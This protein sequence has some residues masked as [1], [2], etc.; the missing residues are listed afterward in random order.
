MK[1]S[2]QSHKLYTSFGLRIKDNLR[3]V[4]MGAVQ[5][6]EDFPLHC[7]QCIVLV[8]LNFLDPNYVLVVVEIVLLY[9]LLEA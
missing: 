7:N 6:I 5:L 2:I 8:P 4:V 9:P 3:A 1:T